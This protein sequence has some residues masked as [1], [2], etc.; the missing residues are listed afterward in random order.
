MSRE[1]GQRPR[2]AVRPILPQRHGVRIAGTGSALPARRVSNTDLEKMMDTT[3]DWIFQRTGIRERHLADPARGE[4]VVSL[5]TEALRRALRDANTPPEALD[6][7]IVGTVTNEMNCPSTACRVA[8]NL[9]AGTAGAFDIA[10][11][12]CGFVYGINIAHEM[13]RGGTYRTIG[14]I[15]CEVLSNVLHFTTEGRGCAILFG[16]A[17][18][19]AVLK[20]TDDTTK[21]II[22]QAI[23]ADGTSWKELFIPRR[24]TDFPPG[25]TPD[26]SKLGV[27]QMNG[28]EVFKFAVT[29]FGDLIGSTL[30]RA[31]LRPDDVDHYVCHQSNARILEA[32]R[33]RFEIPRERLYVNIDRVGNTSAASVP[34][35]L[36]ELRT[37]G[38]IREGDIVMLVAFGAGLT[39]S[40]SLWQL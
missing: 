37:G 29:K 27:M 39:W 5:S 30:E 13:I 22:A 4:N 8:A 19:A 2:T 10:A 11:A 12:C 26:E 23:H 9:G 17:A 15:G 36:D 16:D 35:C 31:G 34:L 24:M 38:K 28:R 14:V 40:S 6:L 20:A 18:G 3:D 21:G 25:V 7:V 1:P 33:E 32:A